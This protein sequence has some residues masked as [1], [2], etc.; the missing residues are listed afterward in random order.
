MLTVR[1][2]ERAVDGA[3]NEAVIAAIASAFFVPK[4]SVSIAAGAGSR[5]KLVEVEGDHALRL[6][7][8]T[9]G[10]QG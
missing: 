10:A 2:R 4:R 8:L 1:V 5:A 7:E 6:S 9:A 3:A